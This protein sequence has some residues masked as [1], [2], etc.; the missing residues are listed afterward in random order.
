MACWRCGE[1]SSAV[2]G[3][4][5]EALCSAWT[6]LGGIFTACSHT[7]KE[8]YRAGPRT[9][10]GS[11]PAEN[12]SQE[13]SQTHCGRILP[14]TSTHREDG[15]PGV[16]THRRKV[17]AVHICAAEESPRRTTHLK[18][19]TLYTCFHQK[20]LENID[21]IKNEASVVICTH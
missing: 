19:Y 8:S 1:D 10:E 16:S 21:K 2:R 6:C 9:V 12:L 15:L 13:H 4:T 20:Y 3:R 18:N 5:G 11:L 14:G 7:E 17:S